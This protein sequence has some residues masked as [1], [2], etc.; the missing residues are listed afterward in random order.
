MIRREFLTGA[1]SLSALALAG[2]ATTNMEPTPV[3]AQP[4]FDPFYVNMYGPL[5]NER[6][7][8]PAVDLRHLKPEYYRRVVDDPTG[9]RPGTLV[10]DTASRYLYLVRENRQAIRYGVGIGRAGFSWSGRGY[11]QYKREWPTWT[12]PAEMI[13]REPHLEE[14]RN[15][16]PGGLDNPLGAR[17]LYIFENGRDTIYR[18]H[19]SGEAWTIGDAVSSGCV[20]LLHQD[21]I[22]LYGRVSQGSPIIVA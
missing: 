10:V 20:R 14:W 1:A 2:C 21:V 11:I 9:E 7:P 19:G 16:Q 4:Q 15:G 18:V 12:P 17:A 13:A 22:D 3:P 8:V 5:P 6:H